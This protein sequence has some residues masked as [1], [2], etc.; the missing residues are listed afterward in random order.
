M[1]S[2]YRY[3]FKYHKFIGFKNYV[4][5]LNDP[6]FLRALGNTCCLVV[7]VVTLVLI[8][9]ILLASLLVSLS[10]RMRTILMVIFYIP[11][12]TSIVTIC[13]AGK[14]I[15]DYRFGTI[16]YIMNLMGF[17]SINWLSDKYTA[18]LSLITFIVYLCLG[19]PIILHTTAMLAIP[20]TYYEAA[21]IDGAT[22]WQQL[23]E[24]TVPL[25][26]PTTLYLMVM[27]TIGSF[28]TFI[29]IYLMTGG[30]PFYRTTTIAYRLSVE[31][32]DLARYGIAS[33]YGVIILVIV[34]SLAIVQYKFFSKDVEY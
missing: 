2:F 12:V 13:M 7:G 30:G 10:D 5:V 32:F 20:R 21:R 6:I 19:S 27:L 28:Q 11:G 33:T 8:I 24:I 34:A 14:W 17:E 18:N 23:W 31:A 25:I 26:R 15:Y 3:T 16:N 22:K 29:I 4:K 9:S 1:F